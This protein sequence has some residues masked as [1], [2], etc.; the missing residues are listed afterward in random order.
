MATNL[1]IVSATPETLEHDKAHIV[2]ISGKI[3]ARLEKA[4]MAQTWIEVGRELA[5]VKT[6]LTKS[7]KTDT[8]RLGWLRS[9]ELN[10]WPIS[11]STA[12]HLISIY[13][14]FSDSNTITENLPAVWDTLYTVSVVFKSAPDKLMECLADGRIRPLSTRADVLALGVALGLRKPRAKSK[15]KGQRVEVP[16]Q[17]APKRER[18]EALWEIMAKLGLKWSDLEKA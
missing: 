3:R 18:I 13:E 14:F 11:R 9:F 7:I 10:L 5:G 8:T 12:E 4:D 15:P 17:T 6:D 2:F 1:K 16:L